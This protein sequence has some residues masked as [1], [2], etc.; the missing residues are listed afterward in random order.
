MVWKLNGLPIENDPRKLPAIILGAMPDLKFRSTE[1][2][3]ELYC[4]VTELSLEMA[5]LEQEDAKGGRRAVITRYIN[6]DRNT[7]LPTEHEKLLE[8]LYEKILVSEGLGRLHGFGF[9]NRWG[10][11]LRGNS[12]YESVKPITYSK[13]EQKRMEESKMK[14]SELVKAAKELN[15]V[16]G[17]DPQIDTKKKSKELTTLIKEAAELIDPELDDLADS[18]LSVVAEVTKEGE[19]ESKTVEEEEVE[20]KESKEAGKEAKEAEKKKKVNKKNTNK[21]RIPKKGEFGEKTLFLLSLI[22]EGK[23]TR[24]EIIEKTLE[25]FPSASKSSLSTLLADSKNPKYNKFDS[26]VKE[27]KDGILSF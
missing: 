17:L 11:K 15:E 1:A 18:T 19:T 6:R 3:Q 27:G 7:K 14:R 23:F 20:F 16:L 9:S 22:K 21:K 5:K 4:G 12:E 24:K 2:L 26:L 8:V 25:K 10:D 13:Q